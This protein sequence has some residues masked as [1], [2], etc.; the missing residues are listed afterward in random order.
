MAIPEEEGVE[1]LPVDGGGMMAV[2]KWGM[3]YLL[4]AAWCWWWCLGVPRLV[5][6]SCTTRD[7]RR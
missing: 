5:Q 7:S 1:N 3:A 6:G 4:S 2:E